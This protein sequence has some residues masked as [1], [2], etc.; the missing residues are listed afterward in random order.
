MR[1]ELGL[2][3]NGSR[4]VP[5]TLKNSLLEPSNDAHDKGWTGVNCST[6]AGV[7]YKLG[8]RKSTTHRPSAV[9]P[10]MHD[11]GAVRI[12]MYRERQCLGW[13]VLR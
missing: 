6:E 11:A 4:S 2:C 9:A 13:I 1:R 12:D 3:V 7:A 10:S 5:E 8:L